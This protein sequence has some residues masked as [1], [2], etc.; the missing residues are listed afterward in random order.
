MHIGSVHK[1]R[2]VEAIFN[3]QLWPNSHGLD[4]LIASLVN[5][6]ANSDKP[7]FC[8]FYTRGV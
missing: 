8:H 7:L 5:V 2:D 3:K 6:N 4:T 1:Y